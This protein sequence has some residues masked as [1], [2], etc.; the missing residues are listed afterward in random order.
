MAF[1]VAGNFSASLC[2]EPL[3]NSGENLHLNKISGRGNKVEE[4]WHEQLWHC[5]SRLCWSVCCGWVA[6]LMVVRLHTANTT[7]TITAATTTTTT[8]TTTMTTT[9]TINITTTN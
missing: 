5:L 1:K 2:Y 7:A 8:T 4:K 9:I 6:P 3:C